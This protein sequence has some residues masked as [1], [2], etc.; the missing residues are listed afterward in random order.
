M[1]SL[2]GTRS[3]FSKESALGLESLPEELT[4]MI[5]SGNPDV[6]ELGREH[7]GLEFQRM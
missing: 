7:I 4:F 3:Q 1:Q 2:A 5:A 6:D